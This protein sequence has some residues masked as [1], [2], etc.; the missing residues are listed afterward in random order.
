MAFVDYGGIQT[1]FPSSDPDG[2]LDPAND[3]QIFARFFT[4]PSSGNQV[5]NKIGGFIERG[6]SPT[7]FRCL[8]YTDNAGVP[9]TI[10]AD[11]LTPEITCSLGSWVYHIYETKPVLV[12]GTVYWLAYW[13]SSTGGLYDLTVSGS[14]YDAG[15]SKGSAQVYSSGGTPSGESWSAL[16]NKFQIAAEYEEESGGGGP[17]SPSPAGLFLFSPPYGPGRGI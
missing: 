16:N 5:I 4:C 6:A 15:N 17:V 8:I 9:G 11:S 13:G 10:V 3:D 1:P 12:G 14:A 7:K 2:G